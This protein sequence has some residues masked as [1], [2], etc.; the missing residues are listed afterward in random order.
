MVSSD[1]TIGSIG[2][3]GDLARGE[4]STDSAEGTIDL[5]R[6]QELIRRGDV[7]TVIVAGVDVQ[8]KLFGKRIHAPHF[9]AQ[10]C[11]GT[12]ACAAVLA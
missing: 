1:G 3:P 7:E 5:A 2:Q 9:L 10:G 11:R 6:L 4:A 8:G 12:L